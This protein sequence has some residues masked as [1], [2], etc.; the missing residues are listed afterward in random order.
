MNK[1]VKGLIAVGVIAVIGFF[2][3][4]SVAI[5][6]YKVVSNY[7]IGTYGYAEGRTMDSL[8]KNFDQKFVE[9]WSK[10]IMNGEQFFYQD[11]KKLVTA[12][13]RVAA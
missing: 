8:K 11:G 4:K 1:N 9:A 2:V 3:Y 10:A 7:L 5:N 13:G 12:T 6:P